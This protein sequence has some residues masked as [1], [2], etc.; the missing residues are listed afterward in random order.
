MALAAPP[1][2]LRRKVAGAAAA[3]QQE[4]HQQRNGRKLPKLYFRK[5]KQ[6]TQFAESGA[7]G[8]RM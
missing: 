4:Q 1:K 3:F 7:C 6:Y 2:K 5:E 8:E